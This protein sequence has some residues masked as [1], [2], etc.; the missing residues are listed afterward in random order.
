VRAIERADR[1][2]AEIEA[3]P[4]R[5]P[6]CVAE[7]AALFRR[8]GD[9]LQ[10]ARLAVGLALARSKKDPAGAAAALLEA[11]GRCEEPRCVAVRRQAFVQ[12]SALL[13]TARDV[14]GAALAALHEEA[15]AATLSPDPLHA[16]SRLAERRCAALPK[17]RCRALA[18]GAGLPPRFRDFSVGRPT[19]ELAPSQVE[20]VFEE[21]APLL[22]HC[23]RGEGARLVPPAELRVEL[24]WEIERD[25]RVKRLS[26]VRRELDGGP[27][28]ACLRAQFS[29]WRY[30]RTAGELQHVEQSFTIR[31]R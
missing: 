6:G 1:C 10:E 20:R 30:P 27:L 26:F 24:R 29:D 17:G 16:T 21:Y 25:G 12:R 28:A 5:P 8:E 4:K 14:E 22:Q 15:L 11:A 7:A 3:R 2:L 13:A 9:R 31:S 18:E 19:A 23:L